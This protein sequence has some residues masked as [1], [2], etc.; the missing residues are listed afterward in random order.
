MKGRGY[1]QH[2]THLVWR[3]L[4]NL[5]PD[6]SRTGDH[7]ISA[8]PCNADAPC[9]QEAAAFGPTCAVCHDPHANEIDPQLRNPK[10]ST[11]FFTFF[12]G[13]ATTN[14]YFT[15][16]MGVI[17]TNTQYANDVFA[18]QYNPEI[19][20]CAQCH[21]SRGAAW[22][23]TSRPPHHSPQ[24]NLLIG[25]VQTNYLNGTNITMIAQHGT[26]ALGCVRCHMHQERPE[27]P[28]DA[29]P[30]KTGH[31]FEFAL[32]TC[33]GAGCHN[34]TFQ[35][36]GFMFGMQ[37]ETSNNIAQIV[38][39]LNQWAT[40]KGPALFTTNYPKYL[41]NAWEFTSRGSLSTI[42]NAGP[43]NADQAKVPALIKQARFNL[44]LVG[45][46]QSLG[47]H[48]PPSTRFL[49]NDASNKVWQTSQ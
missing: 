47:V 25:A 36:Q 33:V 26:N 49:L 10:F 38:N 42:T 34:S 5:E 39:R 37:L 12:N 46:D 30:A 16:W 21:N 28:T 35:A 29:N 3:R 18:A 14:L 40:N 45:Y 1:P 23:G 19:Q 22:Q 20:I 41:E 11:N 44:Y 32:E 48:S 43:S 24:Y 27:T 7:Q 17:T 13:S 31:S 8:R 9:G 2:T 6:S 4:V 15:N